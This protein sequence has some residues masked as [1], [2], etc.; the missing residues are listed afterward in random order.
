MLGTNFLQTESARGAD[1]LQ[2]FALRLRLLGRFELSTGD[3][4]L[5]ALSGRKASCM[6]AYLACV[7]YGVTTRERVCDLLWSRF[8]QKQARDS[9][10]QCIMTVRRSIEPHAPGILIADRQHL[11]LDLQKVSVDVLQLQ[12]ALTTE[13]PDTSLNDLCVTPWLQELEELWQSELVE[14]PM[15][16]DPVFDAWLE[17][18]RCRLRALMTERLTELLA[19]P[20]LAP[21][22]HA[23]ERAAPTTAYG[24][25]RQRASTLRSACE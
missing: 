8:G 11:R 16:G 22:N 15:S 17:A 20:S 4:T 6:L 9:L 7:P 1:Q 25:T 21:S 24:G 2:N 13:P 3:G 14:S 5:I 19:E 10:R 12:D 23:T 18:E